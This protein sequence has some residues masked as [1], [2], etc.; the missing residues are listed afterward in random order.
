[1]GQIGADSNTAE[2]ADVTTAAPRRRRWLRRLLWLPVWFVGFTVLQVAI[3]RF[4]DP[5]FSMM[6]VERQ[7]EAVADGDHDFELYYEWRNRERISSNL[8][9]ALVAA[10]DQTFPSHHGFDLEAI[11]KAAANN[12]KGRKV[13]GGSTIS[14]QTAKNLFL[15][16]GRSWVR[17]GLEA[18]YTLLMELMWPKARILEVY[19][20]IIEYGD[21]IYGAQAASRHFFGKDA[22]Q[23]TPDE[24]SRMAAVLPSPRK[25]SVSKPGPYVQR[26]SRAIQRQMRAL[27]GPG[28]LDFD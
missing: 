12:D 26:R 2:V 6:M 19:A 7:L 24:A 15:W 9:L 27:G 14:Q 23:L 20:N 5:P 1:M 3:L 18:W 22:A 28:Y 8:S 17:K 4:V 11:E 13:R 25:Y 21:G 16:S 10:E